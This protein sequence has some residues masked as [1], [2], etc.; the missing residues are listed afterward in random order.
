MR[1]ILSL[2]LCLSFYLGLS[3]GYLALWKKGSTQP[4]KVFPYNISQYPQIDRKLLEKGI[5]IRSQEEY[6][7]HIEDFLS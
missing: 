3:D 4:E 2:I 5:P 1:K 6:S 7:K